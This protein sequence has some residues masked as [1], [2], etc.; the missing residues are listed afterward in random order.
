MTIPEKVW[1]AQPVQLWQA[2]EEQSDPP[3]EEPVEETPEE[4]SLSEEPAPDNDFD[5]LE[6]LMK[7]DDEEDNLV[8]ELSEEEAPPPEPAKEQ[9]TS[10]A[11]AESEEKPPE[12]QEV[13]Q[14]P[15]PSPQQPQ[16][17]KEAVPP[18][19][20]QPDAKAQQEWF[21]STVEALG[22]Q[23]YK[24]SQEDADLLDTEPSKVLPQLAGRMHMQ[25][26]TAT[27][28]QVVNMFPQLMEQFQTQTAEYKSTE[29]TFYE[30]Y[31]E[32]RGREAEVNQLAAQL[33]AIDKKKVGQEFM[34][35]LAALASVR[36][37]IPIGQ[38]AATPA[39]PRPQASPPPPM[40]SAR[41][42]TRQVPAG[43]KTWLDDIID[44]E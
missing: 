40:A 31:S 12:T 18:Q 7:E 30:R 4:P 42:S 3:A 8:P 16:P 20:N 41:G 17:E 39:Q 38:Q 34:E 6:D 9:D 26:M 13:E 37:R 1:Y 36:L 35:E 24:L 22:D 25:V 19:T 11:P 33:R 28:A 27:M 32:L 21:D 43:E 2:G 23:V 5:Y 44:M 14:P 29:D 10:P 15:Q